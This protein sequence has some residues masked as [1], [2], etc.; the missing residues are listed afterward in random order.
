MLNDP[1]IKQYL[2]LGS[3]NLFAGQ[4]LECLENSVSVAVF[5]RQGERVWCG[6]GPADSDH[7][8]QADVSSVNDAD[9]C[10]EFDQGCFAYSFALRQADSSE[11]LGSLLVMAKGDK[12]IPVKKARRDV[13]D[14]LDCILKQLDIRLE[15]SAVRRQSDR[16]QYDMQ[17]LSKLDDLQGHTDITAALQAALRLTAEHFQSALAILSIPDRDLHQAWRTDGDVSSRNCRVSF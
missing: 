10:V 16:D 7:W 13:A 5:D 14:I 11:P 15:L 12:R 8:A 9:C 6:P 17:L 3:L 1:G 2:D 4:L